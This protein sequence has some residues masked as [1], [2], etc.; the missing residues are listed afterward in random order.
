VGEQATGLGFSVRRGSSTD[1]D[2][3]SALYSAVAA[4]G[5]WIGAEVPVEWTSERKQAWCRTADDED[6][7]AWFLAD[8]DATHLVGYLAVS[9]VRV[10]RAEFAMAVAAAHRGLG[11]GGAL[12]DA[13]VAW[14][15]AIPLSKISCQVW[16]HNGAA[17]ALYR[18]RGFRIEGRLRRHW[19]R[20]NGQLWDSI[21]MG[22]V[23][24]EHSPGSVLADAAV[25][26]KPS[27]TA[28]YTPPA[29]SSKANAGGP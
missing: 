11:V 16:P 1:F 28:C 19:R 3:V 10:E 4:E 6:C 24:D 18:S 25:I 22:L 5:L 9:R 29:G 7:G 23:L 14:C 27:A 21:M 26:P 17:L 15:Q 2:A 8:D 13:A 20:R 12:L